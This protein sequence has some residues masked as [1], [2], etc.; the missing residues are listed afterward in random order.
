MNKYKSALT[1]HE[2]YFL[3]RLYDIFEHKWTICGSWWRFVD[4]HLN[5]HQK[6]ALYPEM[7][8]IFSKNVRKQCLHACDFFHVWNEYYNLAWYSQYLNW[9]NEK[10]S[11]YPVPYLTNYPLH[12]QF[13]VNIFSMLLNKLGLQFRN[14]NS[15]LYLQF[16]FLIYVNIC[17]IQGAIFPNP[18]NI[19]E[20]QI[21]K[22]I[23]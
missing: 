21:W 14:A 18:L 12:W 11:D 7:S 15:A 9:D 8:T 16:Q 13:E 6:Y 4:I 17:F 20:D 23:I 1:W 3:S 10:N 5:R 2:L 19:W 22:L